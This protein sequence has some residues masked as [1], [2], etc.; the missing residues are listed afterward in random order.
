MQRKRRVDGQTFFKWEDTDTFSH[1]PKEH[2][3][4]KCTDIFYGNDGTL[5]TRV[6]TKFKKHL[7]AQLMTRLIWMRLLQEAIAV[8]T[9]VNLD[10]GFISDVV[11][12]IQLQSLVAMVN[13]ASAGG[14]IQGTVQCINATTNVPPPIPLGSLGSG[15]G[16][17]MYGGS[18]AKKFLRGKHRCFN[19]RRL[20][21]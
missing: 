15:Q 11:H 17:S 20:L 3:R 2:R 16:L 12:S 6:E 8:V 21:G 7:G 1:L 9:K 5:R 10:I 4:L 14:S 19:C 18:S 13:A